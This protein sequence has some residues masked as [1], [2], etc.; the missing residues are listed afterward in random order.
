MRCIRKQPRKIVGRASQDSW[1]SLQCLCAGSAGLITRLPSVGSIPAPAHRAA[2]GPAGKMCWLSTA[3]ASIPAQ[4]RCC[5]A[6][7]G[8]GAFPGAQAAVPPQTSCAVL[9]VPVVWNHSSLSIRRGGKSTAYQRIW[10][11]IPWLGH[12]RRTMRALWM[13]CFPRDFQKWPISCCTL[14]VYWCT[15]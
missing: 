6:G 3:C 4:H 7:C 13:Y 14:Q 12:A 10:K 5:L 15:C 11:E 2:L 8:A 1:H 9:V